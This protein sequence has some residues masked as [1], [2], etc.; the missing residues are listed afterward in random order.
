LDLQ[1]PN[2]KANDTRKI[3]KNTSEKYEYSTC[4]QVSTFFFLEKGEKKNAA[5]S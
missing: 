4:V 1:E 5:D 2:V 3:A